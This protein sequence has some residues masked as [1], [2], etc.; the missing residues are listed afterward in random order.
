MRKFIV[1][2]TVLALIVSV[3]GTGVAVFIETEQAPGT[4]TSTT[5]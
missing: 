5:P 2:L 3:L 4:P 1:T